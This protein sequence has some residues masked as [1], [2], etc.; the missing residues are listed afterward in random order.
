[1][2]SSAKKLCNN[3]STAPTI[4]RQANIIILPCGLESDLAIVMAAANGPGFIGVA[5]DR[6]LVLRQNATCTATILR[7]LPRGWT[8]LYPANGL[9]GEPD[10]FAQALV[11]A[12]ENLTKQ[13]GRCGVV[14]Q[15]LG[16]ETETLRHME[17]KFKICLSLIMCAHIFFYNQIERSW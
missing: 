12:Q 5:N 4:L 13:I 10:V 2:I 11:I 16:Q 9:F 15:L 6:D 7:L 8:I 3:D 1:M 17:V 14:K